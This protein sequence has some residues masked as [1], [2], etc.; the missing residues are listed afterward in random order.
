MSKNDLNSNNSKEI[1]E[2]HVP[3]VHR[4]F[5]KNMA[6]LTQLRFLV[7]WEVR[8]EEGMDAVSSE[9]M[10]SLKPFRSEEMKLKPQKLPKWK[11]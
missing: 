7:V 8:E 5:S 3:P 11:L 9:G 10:G 4:T 6:F 2:N 1:W